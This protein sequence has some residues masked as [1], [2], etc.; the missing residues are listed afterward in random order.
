MVI[1]QGAVRL[2]HITALGEITLEEQAAELEPVVVTAGPPHVDPL[3]AA[4]GADL[5]ATVI[6]HLPAGRD[7]RS[8]VTLLPHA[9]ESF[10]GDGVNIAGGTGLENAYFVDGANV[11]EPY[12]GDGGIDLPFD[13]IDYLQ[14][15]TV[16]G[17]GGGS[18]PAGIALPTAGAVSGGEVTLSA[19]TRRGH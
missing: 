13:L 12:R 7:Y 9:N 16:A 1:E 15:K 6:E 8:V 18:A 14:L 5:P 11:T 4:L 10:L 3:T 2:G 17:A 19:E